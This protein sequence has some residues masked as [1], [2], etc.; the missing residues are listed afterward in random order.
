MREYNDPTG[1]YDIWYPDELC[2]AFNRNVITVMS[3]YTSIQFTIQDDTKQYTDTR[4]VYNNKATIDISMYLQLFFKNKET[5]LI[6]SKYVNVD[7]YNDSGMRIFKFTT[8]VIWGVMNIREVFNEGY[9]VRWF[10]NYPQTFSLYVTDTSSMRQIDGNR[11]ESYTLQK[12][13]RHMSLGSVFPGATRSA[14]LIIGSSTTAVFDYT[15][16]FTFTNV[17]A[18][19]IDVEVS[20]EDCGVF[21]RWIDRHGFYRYWLFQEGN[22][23][24]KATDYGDS[25]EVFTDNLPTNLHPF[26]GI[27]RSQGKKMTNQVALCASLVDQETFAMLTTLLS[28]PLP[29]MWTGEDWVPIHVVAGSSIGASE[30]LQDFEIQIVLPEIKTQTL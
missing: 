26:Y 1:L 9:K 19:T 17:T 14:Q 11:A 18:K 24:Y 16:D 15:F 29:S 30:T 20:D 22:K 4:E 5:E 12:G 25:V 10:K 2:F 7:I 3:L 28:S 21:L 6:G 23:T 27:T 8:T 13:L